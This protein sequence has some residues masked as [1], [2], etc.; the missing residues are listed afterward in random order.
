MA[1]PI[2]IDA[3]PRERAGKG[4]ARAARRAGMIPAVIYGG[5]QP[6]VMINL[7]EIAFQR[8][9]RDPGFFTH[10]YE[11]KVG[12]Q[13]HQVIARDVQ[14]DPVMDFPVHVDFLRVSK[15][16]KIAVMVPVTFINEDKCPGL[17]VGGV[18]NVVRH[19][20][21]LNCPASEI[22]DRI[23]VDLAGFNVSESI[24]ISAVT[25]PANVEPTITDRDFTVATIAAPS[26]GVKAAAADGEGEDG[27]ES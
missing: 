13:S 10:L 15:T 21:E 16:T 6:P 2:T 3:E 7:P 18:L 17:K 11:V 9:L 22:P 24:H 1:E 20:V 25:L 8:V 12:E 23:T 19:E 27:A 5:K 26:G 14:L 4:A